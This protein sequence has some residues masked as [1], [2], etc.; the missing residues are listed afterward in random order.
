[1]TV[2][3]QIRSNW[4]GFSGAPGFTNMY[5]ETTDPLAA[6]AATATQ[7]VATF[8]NSVKSVLPADVTVVC[9]SEVNTIDDINGQLQDSLAVTGGGAV[10][11]G[12]GVYSAPTG[13]VVDWSTGAIYEGHRVVGR[14]FLVPL[15]GSVYETN[16]TLT[17]AAI[18][19]INAAA[20][21]LRLAAGPVFGVWSR[22]FHG[23]PAVGTKP[24][25]PA[26]NGRFFRATSNSVPDRAAVLRSRRD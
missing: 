24:A 15:V 12:A 22:P 3:Y 16:G 4:T 20:S 2:M 6:G 1:M 19:T 11:S 10:G 17:T 13:A 21:A 7:N 5:F 8:W 14:T 9:D 18:N 25:R 23:A 26:H